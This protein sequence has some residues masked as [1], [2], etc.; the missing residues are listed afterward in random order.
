MDL[1]APERHVGR[2]G[3][4]TTP[5]GRSRRCEPLCSLLDLAFRIACAIGLAFVTSCNDTSEARHQ[6]SDAVVADSLSTPPDSATDVADEPVGVA[7]GTGNC[8]AGEYC[9]CPMQGICCPIGAL[10]NAC[11]DAATGDAGAPDA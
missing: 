1:L 8:D 6:V 2:L 9:H 4:S 11:P 10:C 3:Q 7:C 5:L